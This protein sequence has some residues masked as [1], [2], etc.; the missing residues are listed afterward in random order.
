MERSP[1]YW[2]GKWG[3]YAIEESRRNGLDGAREGLLDA[4]RDVFVVA[5]QRLVEAVGNPG[6]PIYEPD[7]DVLLVL[8]ACRT[9]LLHEVAD[10]Y[11]FLGEIG[12][13][14]SRASMSEDWLARNF[15]PE[16][17]DEMARTA[18]V[19]G[20]PFARA[21]DDDSFALLD[22]VWEYAWDEQYHTIPAR[23][24]TDRAIDT[25]R[26]REDNG[27]EQMVVH[28]MQPHAPFVPDPNLGSF[29]TPDD[30]GE[31]SFGSLW[32]EAGYT[33]PADEVWAAYRD[34]LRYV[35]DDIEVLLENMDA[36][37]VAVTADHGNAFGE[38]G[39]WGHDS[40]VLLPSVRLVPWAETTGRDTGEYEPSVEPREA[41]TAAVEDR[42]RALGYR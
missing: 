10:E 4:W 29:G 8:D 38:F 15:T 21:L 12:T 34:N 32:S 13:F 25:W 1:A 35:L 17:A 2:L 41:D 39:L 22:E 37:R 26:R 14:R 19:T 42:L 7:W 5:N 40:D 18:Y 36:E 27:V 28:Y 30:F 31:G 3:R 33:I 9:D 23:P 20:N 16:Y 11:E 24:L 6:R